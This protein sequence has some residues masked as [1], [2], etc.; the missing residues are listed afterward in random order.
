MRLCF[1]PLPST[2]GPNET[3]D[4]PA[5]THKHLS[6][7]PLAGTAPQ[8]VTSPYLLTDASVTSYNTNHTAF[9]ITLTSRLLCFQI[10][11]FGVTLFY[12]TVVCSAFYFF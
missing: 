1:P 3:E 4:S 2:A 6:C 11:M 10:I 7:T 8:D 12:T 5:H 9:F